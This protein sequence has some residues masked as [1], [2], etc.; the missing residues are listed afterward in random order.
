[1]E[2]NLRLVVAD[3]I[4]ITVSFDRFINYLK[5]RGFVNIP[6]RLYASSILFAISVCFNFQHND[7]HPT[8]AR[9][10]MQGAS[11]DIHQN[12]SCICRHIMET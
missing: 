1:M 3:E 10:K 2:S 5:T 6:N 9:W 4:S 12:I 11:L 7:N 8:F